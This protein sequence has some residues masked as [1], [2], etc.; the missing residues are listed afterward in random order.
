MKLAAG[1]QP[2]ARRMAVATALM[3]PAVGWWLNAHPGALA[4]L[5]GPCRL[6]LLTGIPCPT[7]GGTHAVARLAS[8]H[9]LSA[10][11]TNPLVTVATLG[12]AAWAILG[13]ITTVV[14]RW[15]RQLVAS[16]GDGRRLAVLAVVL[17]ALDW[18]WLLTTGRS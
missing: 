6:H 17:L 5:V 9:P 3:L 11:A 7:C 16:P 10:L 13:V 8:G 14:P 2:L 15:R 18:L 12:L 1:D 4:T